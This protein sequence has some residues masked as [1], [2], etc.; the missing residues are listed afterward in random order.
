MYNLGTAPTSDERG[1]AVLGSEKIFHTVNT[2]SASFRTAVETLWYT[3]DGE[4][5]I[6]VQVH[7]GYEILMIDDLLNFP[8]L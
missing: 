7:P 5:P 2:I 4:S 8:L 3:V 1:G 6:T